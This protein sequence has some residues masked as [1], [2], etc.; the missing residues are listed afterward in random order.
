MQLPGNKSIFPLS[1]AIE[2]IPTPVNKTG[3]WRFLTPVLRE[4]P[5]PC[6]ALCP[7]ESGIPLWMEKVEK[8]NWEQA[9]QVMEQFN[10]FPALTGYACYQ[11]CRSGCNRENWDGAIAIRDIEK[12]LGL[13][14]QKN[15]LPSMPDKKGDSPRVIIVGSGPAGLSGAYYL[16]RMGAKVTILEKELVAG[17]FLATGIPDYRLPREIL[18]KELEILQGEGIIIKSGMEVGKDLLLDDLTRQCDALLLAVGAGK[19]SSLGVPGDNLPGVAGAIGFLKEINLGRRPAVSGIV[20]V[21]G[22][23]NAA[24][25]AASAAAMSGASEVILAYRRS[26]EVMPAHPEEVKAARDAGVK[27]LFNVVLDGIHGSRNVEEVSF[28]RVQPT[29]R[30]EEIRRIPGTELKIK[31]QM[32]IGATGQQSNLPEL[33]SL[34][35]AAGGDV[36]VFHENGCR[37]LAAGDAVSGPSNLASAIFSG[38]LAALKLAKVLW[39]SDSALLLSAVPALANKTDLVSFDALNPSLYFRQKIFTRPEEE[40]ARCFGCGTCRNCGV[41]WAFCPDLAVGYKDGMPEFNLDYCKGCGICVAEC[42]T[43]VLLMEVDDPG[44]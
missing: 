44:K 3:L 8:G 5:A 15:Y 19:V 20:V 6:Q 33:V 38:R 37:L 42:P 40:A 36:V 29:Q 31:C 17:G 32:V 2:F 34:P 7:L 22:G 16:N 12:A 21:I 35:E 10:P 13:W 4:K 11:F 18:N 27:F 30:K 23:G 24:V 41:C 25:D 14:R 9:W 26:E 1:P 28:S 39:P 43:G